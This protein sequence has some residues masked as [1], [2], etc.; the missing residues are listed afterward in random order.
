M[1]SRLSSP[2]TN[3]PRTLDQLYQ[4]LSDVLDSMTDSWELVLVNDG[5]PD[6]SWERLQEFSRSDQRVV[7]INLV[8]NFGQHNALMCR[9]SRSKGRY[10]V[11]M[12]DDLQHPPEEIPKLVLTLEERGAD[13]VLGSYD[14]NRQSP[15]R[16]AGSL[17]AK[18]VY[19]YLLG[20]PKALSPTSFRI[21][22]KE[23]V[24]QI[25]K[26]DSARPRVGLILFSITRNVVDIRTAHHARIEGR[27][28]YSLSHARWRFHGQHPELLAAP[29][30][31]PRLCGID[32][33]PGRRSVD[34]FA[35]GF[36]CGRRSSGAWFHAA[37]A[38]DPR[39]LRTRA[40][41]M[42]DHGRVPVQERAFG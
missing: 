20:I 17:L 26:Y 21:I 29:S 28:G 33:G 38:L 8:R 42:R 11:T 3:P 40:D 39:R 16:K 27:S 22:R 34:R 6:E 18:Q 24:E 15:F 9:L 30:P 7:S 10:V 14:S 31:A 5:S 4:R 25:V 12:D 41:G 13:A 2:S 1:T 32:S 19:C 35:L 37:R 23:I 36:C